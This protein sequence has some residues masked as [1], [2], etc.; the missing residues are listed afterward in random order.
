MAGQLHAVAGVRVEMLVAAL[1]VRSDIQ[2]VAEKLRATERPVGLLV[3]N[4]GAAP[5][6]A[7]RRRWRSGARK[8]SADV[9][10]GAVL[11]PVARGHRADDL[12]R[13]RRH[14]QRRVGGRAHHPRY[15]LRAQGVGA[16]RSPKHLA[17]EK[18]GTGVTATVVC[19]GFVHTEFHDSAGI[20]MTWLPAI[21]WL[22]AEDV[23]AAALT[24]VRR[25]T[26]ICTPSL[27]YRLGVR[28]GPHAAPGVRAC[29]RRAR[30]RP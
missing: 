1:S 9:M 21:A 3:N 19:P 6:A 4:A 24:A 17:V 22:R 12:A 2:R 11:V 29:D 26:V 30:P 5:R 10:V 27:R 25:G 13:A 7:V 20:D 8:Q 15:V 18:R 16:G 28:R 14:P 23:V